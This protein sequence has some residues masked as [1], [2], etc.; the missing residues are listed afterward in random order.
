MIE[1]I[2]CPKGLEHLSYILKYCE[3]K[4]YKKKMLHKYS[5]QQVF[6]WVEYGR[7]VLYTWKIYFNMNCE[8]D[9]LVLLTIL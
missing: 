2:K 9:V 1:Y 6:K 5:Y 3:A 8:K 7:D 4:I